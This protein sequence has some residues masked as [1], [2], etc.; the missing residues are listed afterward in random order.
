MSPT[1]AA[2]WRGRTTASPVVPEHRDDRDNESDQDGSNR[3]DDPP[4]GRQAVE[5]VHAAGGRR[6]DEHRQ[7]DTSETMGRAIAYSSRLD[8]D[9]LPSPRVSH[10]LQIGA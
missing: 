5:L 1:R 3:D 8:T 4:R 10:H 2:G 7:R 6:D 9:L